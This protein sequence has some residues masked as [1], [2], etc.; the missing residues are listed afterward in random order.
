VRLLRRRPLAAVCLLAVAL[1]CAAVFLPTVCKAVVCGGGLLLAAVLFL[2]CKTGR[3]MRGDADAGVSEKPRN[4]GVFVAVSA[5]TVCICMLSSLLTEDLPVHRYAFL[6]EGEHTVTARVL[7]VSGT[8]SYVTVGMRLTEV[9]NAAAGMRVCSFFY[10]GFGYEEGDVLTFSATADLLSRQNDDDIW[11]LADGYRYELTPLTSPQKTGHSFSLAGKMRRLRDRLCA[12]I[13][14]IVPQRPA[15]LFRALLLGDR[16]GL[17]LY[18][19]VAFRRLGIG[20]LLALSGLH[21][22][23][24]LGFVM[25]FIRRLCP[26]RTVTAPLACLLIAAYALLTGGSVSILRAALMSGTAML[27]FLW[28]T[29][30]D[31]LTALAAAG[32]LLMFFSPGCVYD[33]AFWLS[34]SATL[35]ILILSPWLT[36]W[37]RKHE[38][39]RLLFRRVLFPILLTAVASLFTLLPTALFFG[40]ISTVSIP[41]N[42]LIAPMVELALCLSL[43]LPLLGW[44]PG[45][46]PFVGFVAGKW[47]ALTLDAAEWM[48]GIP[49]ATAFLNHPL[50]LVLIFCLSTAVCLVLFGP[51]RL[52]TVSCGIVLVFVIAVVAAAA[53]VN[54]DA[55]TAGYVH[56]R[57]AGSADALLVSH[58]GDKYLILCGRGTGTSA[59]A[60]TD[61]LTQERTAELEAVVLAHSHPN[62]AMAW[63]RRLLSEAKIGTV[64]LPADTDPTAS[65]E[66]RNMLSPFGTEVEFLSPGTA[67]VLSQDTEILV[68]PE[69]EDTNGREAFGYTLTVGGRRWTLLSQA[70]PGSPSL[71]VSVGADMLDGTVIVPRHSCSTSLPV[72]PLYTRRTERLI[73]GRGDVSLSFLPGYPPPPVMTGDDLRFAG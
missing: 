45:I 29:R 34:F 65:E 41:A 25:A 57:A 69:S 7:S 50:I 24:L 44:I 32:A 58:S 55:M 39:H 27:S 36:G 6:T 14:K 33:C 48:A 38:K 54:T 17:P 31:P 61:M 70:M 40:R 59:R 15:Q 18:D 23:V 73:I 72:T 9:D 21:L 46:G 52:M 35:G 68:F 12:G 2:R 4:T 16:S 49:N 11:L 3:R 56:Y 5:L 42:L 43:F 47:A 62:T 71:S 13:E 67:S 37:E 8:G 66:L 63:L 19:T 26:Y 20:H 22:S 60:Q 51:K 53:R 30:R 64:Y 1:L 10:D 28:G